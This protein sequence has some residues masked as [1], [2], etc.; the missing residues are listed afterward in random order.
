[1]TDDNVAKYDLIVATSFSSRVY[2]SLLN[3]FTILPVG[4]ANNVE[5]KGLG[6]RDTKRDAIGK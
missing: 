6:Y 4:V 5:T 3:R 1:M 2:T